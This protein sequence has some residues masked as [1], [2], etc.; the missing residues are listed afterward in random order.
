MDT[1][2]LVVNYALQS[3]SNSYG[4]PL[5]TIRNNVVFFKFN[6]GNTIIKL[7]FDH[8][9]TITLIDYISGILGRDYVA[10]DMNVAYDIIDYILSL[11][12]PR[13]LL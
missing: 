13:R 4:L 2:D 10:D 8:V 1:Q 5:L 6:K 11:L 3:I 9:I 7:K 12:K